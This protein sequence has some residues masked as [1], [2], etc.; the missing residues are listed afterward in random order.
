[1]RTCSR[2]GSTS[3]CCFGVRRIPLLL[4]HRRNVGAAMQQRRGLSRGPGTG[5]LRDQDQQAP[6]IHGTHSGGGSSCNHP[7][8]LVA[9]TSRQRWTVVATLSDRFSTEVACARNLGRT[10]SR[11]VH[12]LLLEARWSDIRLHRSF[13]HGQEPHARTL[14][15]LADSQD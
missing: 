14:G 3:A 10:A 11:S 1:M 13:V 12:S 4:A 2:A 6:R 5:S 8:V 9:A 7:F 15:I